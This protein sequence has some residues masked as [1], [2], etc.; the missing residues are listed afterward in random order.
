MSHMG[1]PLSSLLC[2][3]K[4]LFDE[5]DIRRELAKAIAAAEKLQ[6]INSEIT[7]NSGTHHILWYN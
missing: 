5:D 1:Q 7:I 3:V 2:F 4:V 6:R